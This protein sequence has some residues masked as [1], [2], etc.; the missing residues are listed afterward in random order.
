MT[1]SVLCQVRTFR[2]GGGYEIFVKSSQRDDL[3]Q[4][5]QL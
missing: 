5:V 1:E 3:Q 2:T 4:S